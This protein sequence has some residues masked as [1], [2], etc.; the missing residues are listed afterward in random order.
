MMGLTRCYKTTV[1]TF[2]NKFKLVAQT[3]TLGKFSYLHK[4]KMAA[5]HHISISIFEPRIVVGNHTKFVQRPHASTNPSANFI[6]KHI[7][8]LSTKC[9]E[10]QID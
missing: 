10:R 5:D 1:F 3:A 8:W 9:M 2:Y 4:S 7:S 6:G